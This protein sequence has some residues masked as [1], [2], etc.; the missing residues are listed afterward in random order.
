MT[1][2]L[3]PK[4]TLAF[5]VV[6]L[7]SVALVSAYAG[8]F[9]AR[10]F[11]SF[12]RTQGESSFIGD[13]AAYYQA[14]GSWAGVANSALL[15]GERSEHRPNWPPAEG[16]A[17]ADAEG[18]V[19]VANQEWAA[20]EAL[21]AEALALGTPITLEGEV[22]GYVRFPRRDDRREPPATA[23]LERISRAF[24]VAVLGTGALALVIG[25]L[26]A[27]T[28]TR[29]LRA[30]TA[31]TH[32]LAEGELGQQVEVRSKDEIGELAASFNQMSA[33][34]ARASRLRRQMTADVAHELRAPLSLI[35]AHAE[36]L[37]DGVFPPSVETFSLIH[38][39][40][41]RLSRLVDDLRTL[42]LAD[43]GELRLVKRPTAPGPL[44]ERAVAMQLVRAQGQEVALEALIAPDLPEV[45]VDADRLLQVLGNLLDNA[46]RHTP[47]GGQVRCSATAAAGEVT[48]AIADN[49][50]GIAPEDLPNIFERFYRADKSRQRDGSGS[51]LGLAISKAIVEAHGGRIQARSD[52][53]HGA[54]LSVSLPI[55]VGG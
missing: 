45:Q 51:G 48:F 38:D 46:L 13:L 1:R 34:L 4:L 32:A 26:L 22:V 31:A 33:N 41:I 23:A 15:A 54:T 27:R 11:E 18:R 16:L 42:S 8:L 28:L 50:P 3:A 30:L 10:E 20:G 35:Q 53:G 39:E 12:A 55:S 47:V 36:A 9:T 21:P 7:L 40:A 43:A 6:S 29:P 52:Q 2:S 24:G 14:E 17:L 19:L 5:M 44:L 49:G 37:R 25:G